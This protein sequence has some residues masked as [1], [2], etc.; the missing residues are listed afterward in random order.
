[1]E[2]LI[3]R[4]IEA[5]HSLR[6]PRDELSCGRLY[7]RHRRYC[8]RA[9]HVAEF[10]VPPKQCR[11]R[12]LPSREIGVVP[13]IHP[14]QP[15]AIEL[16]ILKDGTR[17]DGRIAIDEGHCSEIRKAEISWHGLAR[18]GGALEDPVGGSRLDRVVRRRR[19]QRGWRN[20]VSREG[21]IG[22]L[23]LDEKA[24]DR[25]WTLLHNAW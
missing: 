2:E 8:L 4:A 3:R 21:H 5:R 9:R 22:G 13:G 15:A 23:V 7:R 12:N 16:N 6:P 18:D 1:M 11:G 10:H 19:I 17:L 24:G 25:P 20:D 14:D